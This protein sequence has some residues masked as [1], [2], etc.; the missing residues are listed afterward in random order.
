MLYL[1][2]LHPRQFSL[3]GNLNIT[4]DEERMMDFIW[5]SHSYGK[6]KPLFGIQ[7]TNDVEGGNSALLYNKFRTQTVYQAIITFIA[8]CSE[9]RTTSEADH[10]KLYEN[11]VTVTRRG[12]TII[13]IMS[14]VLGFQQWSILKKNPVHVDL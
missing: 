5:G 6:P 8:R 2:T 12:F 10:K 11:D 13:C 7:T 14:C 3:V 4:E 9:E 1:M